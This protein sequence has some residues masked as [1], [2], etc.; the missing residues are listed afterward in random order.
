VLAQT[1]VIP[2]LLADT[3]DIIAAAWRNTDG[4]DVDEHVG[5]DV[6]KVVDEDV[7]E[8]VDNQVREDSRD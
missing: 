4:S 7:D 5:M 2:E 1:K 3:R 8:D 6:D